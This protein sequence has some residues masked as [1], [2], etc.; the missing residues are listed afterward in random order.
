M[1]IINKSGVPN[2]IEAAAR[3]AF[4]RGR[5]RGGAHYSVTELIS[6]PQMARLERLHDDEIVIDVA[7]LM[8]ALMGVLMARIIAQY[9]G[10]IRSAILEA[11]ASLPSSARAVIA[12]A[13][14]QI[15][16]GPDIGPDLRVLAERRLFASVTIH[17]VEIRVSGQMDHVLAIEDPKGWHITDW[18]VASVWEAIGVKPEREQQ[19]NLYAALLRLNG[20]S[21]VVSVGNGFFFRDWSKRRARRERDYPQK[22]FANMPARLWAEEQA[23]RYLMDRTQIH[24]EAETNLPDCTYEE[25]WQLPEYWAVMKTAGAKKASRLLQSRAEAEG[26]IADKVA[27][28]ENFDQAVIVHRPTEPIRCLDYCRA[29]PFCPQFKREAPSPVAVASRNG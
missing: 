17:G 8:Y 15:G 26:W 9:S 3:A 20:F 21:P 18:K 22:Q 11:A 6:P 14:D 13:L 24:Y 25:K 10:D 4:E 27:D 28:G 7:D 16:Y 1:R 2:P 12:S 23:Y 5:D 19:L 29:Q